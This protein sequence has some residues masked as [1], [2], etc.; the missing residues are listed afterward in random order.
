MG[1]GIRK[2]I[3]RTEEGGPSRHNVVDKYYLV[4]LREDALDCECL[5]T[6]R[7]AVVL[8]EG[9]LHADLDTASVRT[10]HATTSFPRPFSTSAFASLSGT[11]SVPFLINELLGTGTRMGS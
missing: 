7:R 8:S 11:Q 6:C 4:R 3:C 5:I 2:S 1:K 9:G 10:R